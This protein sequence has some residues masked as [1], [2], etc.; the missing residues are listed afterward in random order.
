MFRFVTSKPR[1]EHVPWCIP[2]GGKGGGPGGG[3]EPPPCCPWEPA[4]G[5]I[6]MPW[7][8][9]GGIEPGGGTGGKAPGGGMPAED[10]TV[11]LSVKNSPFIS[12]VN[13]TDDQVQKYGLWITCAEI[14]T[15]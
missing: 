12:C 6:C 14:Y 4:L 2:A 1:L 8:M 10:E 11:K 9:P 7:G 13:V 5:G 3:P 15:A